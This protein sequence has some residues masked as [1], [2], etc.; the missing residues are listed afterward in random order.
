MK[1]RLSILLL[2]ISLA[3]TTGC[4]KELAATHDIKLN[5]LQADE[6][7]IKTPKVT[8][9]ERSTPEWNT[10]NNSTSSNSNTSKDSI[11]ASSSKNV[12][13]A[14]NFLVNRSNRLEK[15]YVPQSLRIP[16]VKFASF[17]DPNV[18]K[19]DTSAASALESLFDAAKKDGIT[20][21]A[22]S[23]YRDYS[24]QEMLYDRKASAV[25]KTEADKYVAQPGASEHQTGLA[26]D[27]G[28]NECATLEQSFDKTQ[29]YKW[30]ESNCY[31]Y[32]FIIR[33]PK[34]KE[35]ITGYNYEP[36]HIR[37]VGISPASEIF[38]RHITLEEYL[39][40]VS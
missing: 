26:M 35:N 17:A 33:Y 4:S 31:K 20:L 24:Y 21:L 23:G 10:S 28:S 25:G 40:K 13:T 38:Q 19:M 7:S 2:S 36:W 5:T 12:L 27:V 3:T 30:I 29:A 9:K 34:G 16:N 6:S 14:G 1:K 18:K 39:S 8:E 11:A 15:N 32:G 22:V 37:Y